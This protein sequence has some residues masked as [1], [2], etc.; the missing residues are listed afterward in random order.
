MRDPG[1]ETPDRRQAVTLSDLIL[2][3]PHISEIG[4]CIHEPDDV[5]VVNRQWRH[6]D[7]KNLLAIG[8]LCA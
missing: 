3:A 6:C 8:C 7:A 5:S 2:Q 1:G 4:K